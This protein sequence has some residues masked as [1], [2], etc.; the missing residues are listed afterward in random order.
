ML[1]LG[2]SFEALL[3]IFNIIITI[4]T[5]IRTYICTYAYE[6]LPKVIFGKDNLQRQNAK[7][8]LL[9]ACTKRTNKHTKNTTNKNNLR[10]EDTQPQCK[11]FPRCRQCLLD[12]FYATIFFAW[13]QLAQ[14]VLQVSTTFIEPLKLGK[15]LI[16]RFSA[17][18]TEHCILYCSQKAVR[19]KN[20][21]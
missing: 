15:I 1:V 19:S 7:V 10:M 5:C 12:G 14:R 20:F 16:I 18:S 21:N 13:Y 11:M 17:G 2:L 4:V 8:H 9:T 6:C 3:P